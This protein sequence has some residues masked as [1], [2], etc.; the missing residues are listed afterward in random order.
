MTVSK[1]QSLYHHPRW[2][3]WF[4]VP[5][6]VGSLGAAAVSV[7]TVVHVRGRVWDALL[8]WEMAGFMYWLIHGTLAGQRPLPRAFVWAVSL[9]VAV[10]LYFAGIGLVPVTGPGTESF[11]TILVFLAMPVLYAARRAVDNL[12]G[13]NL[14]PTAP[15]G[16]R[17]LK[18]LRLRR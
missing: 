3:L 9:P 12:E 7:V 5:A 11:R 6:C 14:R 16:R 15:A 13:A 17:W 8:M 4:L 1:Q 10:V 18:R 2:V